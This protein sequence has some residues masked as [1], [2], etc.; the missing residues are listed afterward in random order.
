MLGLKSQSG[1]SLDFLL[2]FPQIS[3]SCKTSLVENNTIVDPTDG[4]IVVFGTQG[5]II[6]NNVSAVLISVVRRVL[7]RELRR[8]CS[9]RPSP[10][11]TRLR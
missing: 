5:S 9:S 6:R 4:G 3:L 1:N 11:G 2:R 10:F 8:L 7:R